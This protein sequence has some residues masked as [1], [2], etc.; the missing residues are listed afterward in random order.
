MRKVFTLKKNY[1]SKKILQSF[2]DIILKFFPKKIF[3]M[4]L[5]HR[6]MNFGMEITNICNA[7]CTFCAY[8]FQKKKKGVITLES[9]QYLVDEYSKHGGGPMTFTPTVGDPL[10]DPEIIDKI[11]Y[12]WSKKNISSI[13]LYTNGILLDKFGFSNVLKSGLTR[14]AIST[15]VGSKEGYIKYY[16]KNKYEKVVNNIFEICKKNKELNSPVLIT[17]HLRVERNRSIWENTGDFKKIVEFVDP[18]NIHYL[19]TYDSW[20]GKIKIKDLPEGCEIDTSIDLDKKI[21]SGPCFELYRRLHVLPDMNVGA[22]ICVDLENEINIGNLKNQTL[23]EVWRGPKIKSFRS[24]WK[25]GNLPEVCKGC[26]R[27][28]PIDSYIDKNR[29]EIFKEPIKR[30]LKNF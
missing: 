11:K 27:Y 22:C 14:L 13:L 5:E 17:L 16:R 10:V 26:T 29:A 8:R 18:K 24:Q 25:Q 6:F 9:Y 20:S 15:Y 30:F 1:S 3:K 4:I 23:I 7:D 12:A 2:F 21:K 19:T 28:S